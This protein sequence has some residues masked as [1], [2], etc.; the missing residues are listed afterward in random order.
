VSRIYS[1]NLTIFLK[2]SIYLWKRSKLRFS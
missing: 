1:Q 2:H